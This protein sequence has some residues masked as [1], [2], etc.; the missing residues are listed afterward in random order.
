DTRLFRGRSRRDGSIQCRAR[1]VTEA[2]EDYPLGKC[3]ARQK[4]SHCFHGDVRGLRDGISVDAAADRWKGDRVQVVLLGEQQRRS[5]R[6]RKKL[7]LAVRTTA[8]DRSDG[9]DHVA[10]REIVAARDLRVTDSAA[11]ERSA[12]G[13][14]LW[15]RSAMDRTVDTATAK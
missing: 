11:A 5:V 6:G 4:C 7:R 9:V 1:I 2:D 13:E 14:K 15:A 12:F 3:T 8:P 10:C